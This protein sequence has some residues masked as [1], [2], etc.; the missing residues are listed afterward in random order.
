V[1]PTE[2]DPADEASDPAAGEGEEEA[3]NKWWLPLLWPAEGARALVVVGIGIPTGSP[4]PLVEEVEEEEEEEEVEVW[5]WD[6]RGGECAGESSGEVWA[7]V[8][9]GVGVGEDGTETEGD[10][11]S[12]PEGVGTGDIDEYMAADSSRSLGAPDVPVFAAGVEE[13]APAAAG[14]DVR[15]EDEE[16][17][18]SDVVG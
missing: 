18:G 13:V 8:G 14:E 12:D 10:G 4:P 6:V 15:E 1:G 5:A 3:A 11:A 2:V 9:A 7:G 17:E 16:G